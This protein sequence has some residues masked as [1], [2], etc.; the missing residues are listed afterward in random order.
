MQRP[1]RHPFR[2]RSL[3]FLLFHG[4]RVE[5]S[6]PF[7]REAKRKRRDFSVL[8]D[9]FGVEARQRQDQP[10]NATKRALAPRPQMALEAQLCIQKLIRCKKRRT[11]ETN[12]AYF[13]AAA[14]HLAALA[15]KVVELQIEINTTVNINRN[16]PGMNKTRTFQQRGPSA[17]R[18][19]SSRT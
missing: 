3:F 9:V 4:R 15:R 17:H 2:V 1:S 19:V 8:F 14:A 18:V 10:T 11:R 13:F 5:R 6:D 12:L 7:V 16:T